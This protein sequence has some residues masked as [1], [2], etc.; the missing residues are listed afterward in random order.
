MA[1]KAALAILVVGRNLHPRRAAIESDGDD[2]RHVDG[3]V[4]LLGIV[5][6]HLHLLLG[7]VVLLL[8][9]LLHSS[10]IDFAL[11]LLLAEALLVVV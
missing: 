10:A 1:A 11:D 8:I 9:G 3:H 5:E 4:A 6:V 7:V 2:A